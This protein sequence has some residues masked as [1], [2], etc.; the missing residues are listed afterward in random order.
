MVKNFWYF[1]IYSLLLLIGVF[2]LPEIYF[3]PY[4][5]SLIFLVGLVGAWRYGWFTINI[6]RAYLYKNY[7]FKKIRE[8]E[9]KN[10][11]SLDPEH[12]FLL[13]TTFRI[14]TSVTVKVYK[15]AIEEAII[16][17]YDVTI[18]ASIVERSEEHLIRK[19]F[20]SYNPP[21]N[22]KLVISR[23][24]GT[25]K[26]DGL[27]VGFRVVSNS[28]GIDLSKSVVAVIDGD[29]I[30]E[31]GLIKK[32]SR[33]FAL[34]DMLGALTTDEDAILAGDDYAHN[35]YR[36]W[37]KLRFAQRNIAMMSMSLSDRVLTLTG[38]MSMLRASIVATEAF[39]QTVQ[40]DHIDHPRLGVFRFLTGDDKS[41]WF[42]V[43]KE[44]WKMLYVPDVTVYTVE[45]IPD[46]NFLKGSVVLMQ[47][48]FGNQYRT[49]LRAL[50]LT[51]ARLNWYPWY[52]LVDQRVTMWATPYGFFIAFFSAIHWG[53]SIWWAYVWWV[54]FSRLLMTYA[55][56]VSRKEILP[57]WPFF[58]YFNQ[59]IGSF[60]KIYIWDHLYKQ[61]WTRQKTKLK[62]DD[63]FLQKYRKISSDSMTA[64]KIIFFVIIVN[65]LVQ[66]IT[67]D[68][69]WEF[70]F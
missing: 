41:S 63:M 40:N 49:N 22:V 64:L 39:I 27:S 43:V 4:Q 14:G 69:L 28:R 61:S 29:S 55:Y 59:L 57:S 68:D 66:N 1:V 38:R 52:G 36:Q 70:V 21:K 67:F 11:H 13:L 3:D 51:P 32:C 8:L 17:G 65:F 12:V 54:F 6:F 46:K 45:E 50:S 48:W 23:I 58:L 2:A 37:Y 33:L 34:D 16:S 9:R 60:V 15:A 56:R 30:L 35:I 7:K 42:D 20:L 5:K 18:I 53:I 10:A 44:G 19:I 31:R 62:T 26:R 25:G 24:K 47:R